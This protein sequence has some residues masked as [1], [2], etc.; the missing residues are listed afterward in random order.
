[1]GILYTHDFGSLRLL[2][3]SDVKGNH[4]PRASR[5]SCRVVYANIQGHHKNLSDLSLTTRVGDVF[6]FCTKTLVS[7]RRDISELMVQSF[8]RPMQLLKGEV[9][10]FRGLALYVRDC[11]SVYRQ[12]IYECGCSKVIIVRICSSSPYLYVFGVYKKLDL[13][14]K[15]FDRLFT[16]LAKLV[17]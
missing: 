5:R 16:A 9:N 11:F 3:S 12:R 4:G 2:R 10:R 6:L 13:L 14:D 1:M 8:Y 7:S 17:C 15:I